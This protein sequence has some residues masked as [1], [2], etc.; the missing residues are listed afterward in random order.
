MSSERRKTTHQIIVERFSEMMGYDISHPESAKIVFRMNGAAGSS[1]AKMCDGNELLALYFLD[2][3]HKHKTE[4]LRRISDQ[5]GEEVKFKHL[6]ALV[7][8]WPE[9]KPAWDALSQWDR[10]KKLAPYFDIA[11][12][13]R[14][15]TSVDKAPR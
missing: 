12:R 7:N 2:V 13:I 14:R 4:E 9:F 6:H 15:R 10:E 8:L 3:A 11:E 5:K 1:L